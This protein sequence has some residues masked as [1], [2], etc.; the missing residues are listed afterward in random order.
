MSSKHDDVRQNPNYFRL[1]YQV[2]AQ[3]LHLQAS[4]ESR[5]KRR[6]QSLE[7]LR[8]L[9]RTGTF[10]DVDTEPRVIEPDALPA[11][12]EKAATELAEEARSQ[13]RAYEP[14]YAAVEEFEKRP[15]LSRWWRRLTFRRP[16]VPLRDRRLKVFLEATIEP[17][18]ELLRAGALAYRGEWTEADP[19]VEPISIRDAAELSYRVHYNLLCFRSLRSQREDSSKAEREEDT[20][21][22]LQSLRDTLRLCPTQRRRELLDWL[23][24]D[25]TLAPLRKAEADAFEGELKLYTFAIEKKKAEPPAEEN[26]EPDDREAS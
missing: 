20:R 7:W 6:G 15:R 4:Q 2:A 8:A 12:A 18:A 17:C 13:L 5:G 9:D 1:R 10:A 24:R 25:P 19:L 11:A 14:M 3:S 23:R 26:G 21:L 22:A 16:K